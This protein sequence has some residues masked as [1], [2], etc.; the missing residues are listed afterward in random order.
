MEN[1][2][3]NSDIVDIIIDDLKQR[4]Q[5]GISRYSIPLRAFNGK[6]INKLNALQE[7]YEEGMDFLVYLKQWMIEREEMLKVLQFYADYN[8]DTG[9]KA[10]E[11]L[12]KLGEHRSLKA[13]PEE[14]F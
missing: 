7:T 9:T 3:Q 14:C 5:V 8:E 10:T 4:K 1:K 13:P 11:L 12:M 6:E 2:D